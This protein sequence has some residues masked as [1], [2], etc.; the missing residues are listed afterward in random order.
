MSMSKIQ[1]KLTD[2]CQPTRFL[3]LYLEKSI[4]RLNC[5]DKHFTD[6]KRKTFAIR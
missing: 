5:P 3:I 6:R 2:C 1:V 4:Y